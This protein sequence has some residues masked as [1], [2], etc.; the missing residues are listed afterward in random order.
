MDVCRIIVFNNCFLQYNPNFKKKSY[1]AVIH[2][3]LHVA[4]IKF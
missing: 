4:G 1:D 2:L 3:T